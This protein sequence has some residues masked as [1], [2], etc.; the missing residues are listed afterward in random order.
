MPTQLF[1][2]QT[3]L[4]H[5]SAGQT[6]LQAPLTVQPTVPPSD[7]V[8]NVSKTPSVQS[9]GGAN[10]SAEMRRSSL[11][12]VG[13]ECT[14]YLERG[15][16]LLTRQFRHWLLSP[17]IPFSRRFTTLLGA[18]APRCPKGPAPL[19]LSV[20]AGLGLGLVRVRSWMPAAAPAV[21]VAGRWKATM[22]AEIQVCLRSLCSQRKR[23][24]KG[25]PTGCLVLKPGNS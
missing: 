5:I 11:A 23:R 17:R 2:L 18:P 6:F 16:V 25:S 21:C 20:K 8:A 19:R 1:S 24:E 3:S 12:K 4:R 9:M 10:A 13:V 14:K 7:G 15:L 22:A